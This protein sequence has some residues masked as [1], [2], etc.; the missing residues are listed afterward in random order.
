M[1]DADCAAYPAP[2]LDSVFAGGC[3]SNIDF[4]A[5]NACHCALHGSSEAVMIDE[6]NAYLSCASHASK[7][8]KLFFAENPLTSLK[9]NDSIVLSSETIAL[10][11]F[12]LL[13]S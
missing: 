11:M 3:A 12:F 2:D 8:M 10:M 5:A 13:S 9:V 4:Y 1:I 7:H 6:L